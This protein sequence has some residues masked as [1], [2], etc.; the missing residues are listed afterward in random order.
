MSPLFDSNILIDALNRYEPARAVLA[1]AAAITISRIS[2]IEVLAGA[3]QDVRLATEAFL[4]GCQ[5]IEID[6]TIAARAATIRR[7]T[8]LKLPDAIIWA[9]ALVTERMLVTRNTKDF[10]TR[11]PGVHC[12]YVM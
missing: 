10:P 7:E 9:T 6:P 3:G 1:E 2:W 11:W 12:P 5:V 4:R 8:R